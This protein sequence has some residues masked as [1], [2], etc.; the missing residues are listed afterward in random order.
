MRVWHI[1]FA[2]ILFLSASN[3]WG[4]NAVSRTVYTDKEYS[5]MLAC[6]GMTDTAWTNAAQKLKGVSLADATK[7]YDGRLQGSP[8]DMALLIVNQVYKDSFTNAWDYAVSF[9]G[10]CALNIAKVG[11]D[12]SGP[13][14]YCMQNSMIAMTAWEYRNSGQPIENVYP[15]FAKLGA[16]PRSIIDRVYAGSL[17]RA[18][19]GLD[20]WESC[21][22]P[23]RSNPIP[24]PPPPGQ[25]LPPQGGLTDQELASMPPCVGLG[26]TVWTF[27]DLKLQGVPLDNLKKQYE[28]RPASSSQSALLALVDRVYADKFVS[29][30]AYSIRYLDGCAQK[31]ANIA[32]ARMGVANSCLRNAYFAYF[33]GSY[34]K[35]GIPVEKAYAP[36]ADLYGTMASSIMDKVY[37]NSVAGDAGVAE[38]KDCVLSSPTWTTPQ[39]GQEA[40][41]A[42]TPPGYLSDSPT[43]SADFVTKNLYPQGE[44]SKNWTELVNLAAFP[45]LFDHTP[46]AYQKA[47]QG[48]SQACKDGKVI[49]SSLG[50]EDGYAFALWYETCPG[51]P[52]GKIEFR[53]HKVIQGHES[54][55][56]ITK[57]FRSEPT[58]AQAEQSRSY[59]AS[60]KVCDSTRSGQ[61]CPATDAGT[62]RP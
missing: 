36:F 45:G 9:F 51:S 49:S 39:K 52:D 31:N 38:W 42:P 21:V 15:Q 24:P 56:S 53:F 37:R 28:S 13:A 62:F 57:S 40:L 47:V 26:E 29:P 1:G 23:L 25:S 44:S 54:L 27:A 35:S 34:K 43:R 5:G 4:Q 61:P 50:E 32:P 33:A 16:T 46:T 11:K 59:L 48:P 8:K 3:A 22:Q 18:Q 55:Y 14:N 7:Y 30:S 6:V 10:D 17:P 41:L 2:V 19:T 20:L 60:V 58:P 12:R